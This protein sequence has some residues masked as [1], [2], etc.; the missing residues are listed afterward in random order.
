MKT[1]T[2]ARILAAIGLG[3]LLSFFAPLASA[4]PAA[5]AGEPAATGVE[6]ELNDLV[7][8][9]QARLGTLD[10]APAEAQ[11]ADE[12]RQFDALLAA[13]KGEKT[14]DVA[15]VLFMKA[16]LYGEV[17]NDAGKAA[18]ALKQIK[19]DFP[20]TKP[21][22]MADEGLAY[23]EKRKAAEA[24][25]ASLTAGAAFPDF[26][27]K[28]TGGN[29]LSVGKYKGKVVLV[30]FWA[31]WCQ[32]CVEEIPHVLAAYQKYHDKG[33]E[34]IGISLDQDA[35]VLAKYVAG[36]KMPWA[37]HWDNG[38]ELATSY[39]I[40]SIPS[41]FLLDGEGKIVATDL[42]GPELEAQLEKLLGK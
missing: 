12:L 5:A 19:A 31:T 9:I 22:D 27:V 18:E 32:P 1:K 17:F 11:F 28:D 4:Q 40:M 23:L 13:H 20:G 39:G 36:K 7:Q 10:A 42:R 14:D 21:A 35:G 34:V 16:M 41:T 3:A 8:K 29:D 24:K 15:Q 2:L 6:K 37:Q 38:G 25:K 26:A 33:F 30:D